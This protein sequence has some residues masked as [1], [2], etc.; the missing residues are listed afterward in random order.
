MRID[1]FWLVC[2]DGVVR[3]VIDGTADQSD[4]SRLPVRFL[5][6]S[7]ADR[8]VFSAEV[9]GKLGLAPIESESQIGGIGGPVDSVLVQAGL[10]FL[11]TD[12]NAIRFE[13]QIPVILDAE[14]LDMSILGRDIL[15]LFAV[16]I[17]RPGD[18]VCLLAR[19][20]G[21]GITVA[22]TM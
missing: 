6:D 18:V 8:S 12:G 3:P 10:R 17:D 15:N 21:Y 2:D 19:G 13:G 7:G 22:R 1:G 4:G 20:H 5:I 11:D 16:I 14:S 9:Y